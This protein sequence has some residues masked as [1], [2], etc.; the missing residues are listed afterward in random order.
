MASPGSSIRE[1][2]TAGRATLTGIIV[3]NVSRSAFNIQRQAAY[4]I[5]GSEEFETPADLSADDADLR[6]LRTGNNQNPNYER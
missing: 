4:V 1:L 5:C 2:A 6:R 3:Q